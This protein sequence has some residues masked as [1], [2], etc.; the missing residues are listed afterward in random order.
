MASESADNLLWDRYTQRTA[1]PDVL[2]AL[3][4]AV[5]TTQHTPLPLHA[6]LEVVSRTSSEHQQSRL[7]VVA[8]RSRRLAVETHAVELQQ[9]L[10]EKNVSLSSETMKTLGDVGSALVA[11]STNASLLVMQAF[12]S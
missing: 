4:R 8:G 5:F 3:T 1:G 11:S 9:L 10:A 2:T 7:L 6:L 12:L